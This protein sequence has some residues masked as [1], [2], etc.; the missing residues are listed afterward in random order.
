MAKKR[1]VSL[2]QSGG[3]DHGFGTARGG[4]WGKAATRGRTVGRM[5]WKGLKVAVRSPIGNLTMRKSTGRAGAPPPIRGGG[6]KYSKTK[7]HPPV[8]GGH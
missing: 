3:I 4:Q 6:R 2:A 8:S 1:G 5:T 7:I